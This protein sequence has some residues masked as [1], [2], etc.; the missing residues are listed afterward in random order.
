MSQGGL[1]ASEPLVLVDDEHG[2]FV[3]MPGAVA[4]ERANAW[5]ASL[6]AEIP[7]EA[8][9]RA[10]YGRDVD[11]P[12]LTQ[13]YA[14]DDPS[15]PRVLGEA[16]RVVV[17][18]TGIAFTTVGLNLY[19]DGRDSVAPHNDHLDEL[20]E[21]APIALLSLGATR[22]MTLRERGG[23]KRNFDIDLEAGSVLTMSYATQHH[24]DHGIP[25]VRTEVGARISLAFRVRPAGKAPGRR[26]AP[27]AR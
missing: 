25:K 9:R 26:Y 17:D 1:F 20:T 12:R 10:M 22:R 15:L 6:L 11:V 23:R 14:L 16:G 18:V 8:Q 5:F 19:R 24:Y 2:R 13:H 3:Y 7:W 4:T 21:G 27:Q